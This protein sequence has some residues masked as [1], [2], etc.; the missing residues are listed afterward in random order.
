M[1]NNGWS[2]LKE[3]SLYKTVHQCRLY[4]WMHGKSTKYYH[5]R[6]RW[7]GVPSIF[8]SAISGIGT[9]ANLQDD[10]NCSGGYQISAIIIG[11]VMFTVSFLTG[12]QNF[13]NYNQLSEKHGSTSKEYAIIINNI[14]QQLTLDI[15]EREDGT[16]F[17]NKINDQCNNLITNSPDIP[18][19]IWNNFIKELENGTLFDETGDTIKHSIQSGIKAGIEAG[20][21]ISK[22]NS[23]EIIDGSGSSPSFNKNLRES[24]DSTI[25][26]S[27]EEGVKKGVTVGV[28]TYINEENKNSEGIEIVINKDDCDNE[29]DSKQTE[30]KQTEKNMGAGIG[31]SIGSSIGRS[32]NI[33]TNDSYKMIEDS[34]FQKAFYSRLNKKMTKSLAKKYE[35][36]L[37]RFN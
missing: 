23:S 17:I 15:N 5:T 6:D 8:F 26:E 32:E 14:H 33:S 7:L 27:I 22:Q 36:Q 21:E 4:K 29:N 25:E 34:E 11:C 16:Q 28:E 18:E 1:E 30:S 10:A 13:M 3:Q 19:K 9:F 31:G 2:Q 35:Y 37:D 24:V 12:L 20:L